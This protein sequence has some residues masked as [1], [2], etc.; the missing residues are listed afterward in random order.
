MEALFINN[1]QQYNFIFQDLIFTNRLSS[2]V[3]LSLF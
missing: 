1:F 3:N 2:Q